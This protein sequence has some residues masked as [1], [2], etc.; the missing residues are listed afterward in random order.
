MKNIVIFEDGKICRGSKAKLIKR[1]KKRILIEFKEW[2]EDLGKL[3][4]ITEWF[5]LYIP[6]YSRDK[7]KHK[8]NNKRKSAS[9][10]HERTNLFY[11]DERQKK[12]F[13]DEMLDYFKDSEYADIFS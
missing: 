2:N 13:K 1:G 5:K 12:D 10:C 6:S 8:H 7:K 9:Y 4:T 3:E 11:S